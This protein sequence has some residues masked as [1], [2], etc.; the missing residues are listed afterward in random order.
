MLSDLQSRV[1]LPV[2]YAGNHGL[3]IQGPDFAFRAPG[4]EKSLAALDAI[5]SE[6]TGKLAGIRGTL[7]EHKSLTISVHFRLVAPAQKPEVQRLV[8]EATR[9]RLDAVRLRAGKEIVE[10]RPAIDWNKG[11]AARW[12]RDRLGARDW[13]T[14]C[15]GDDLT[16]EDMFHELPDA[17]SIKVGPG[18]TAA[19]FRVADTGEFATLLERVAAVTMQQG[20]KGRLAVEALRGTA[21]T[22]MSTDEIMALTRGKSRHKKRQR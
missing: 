2:I 7:I 3:E 1:G 14:V 10:I 8:E 17:V 11:T 21:D 9:S 6:L 12:I 22:Q 15:A 16:D 20:F 19:R 4:S 13:L 18:P 5:D